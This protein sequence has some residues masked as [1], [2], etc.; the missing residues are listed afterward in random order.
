MAGLGFMNEQQQ[1]IEALPKGPD[2]ID[3]GTCRCSLQA[4]NVQQQDNNNALVSEAWRCTLN[5]TANPYVGASGMWFVPTNTPDSLGLDFAQNE[6]WAGNPPSLQTPYILQGPDNRFNGS[7][8]PYNSESPSGLDSDDQKC[9]G[10]NDTDA[11][12]LYYEGVQKQLQKN[13]LL[14][15]DTCLLKGSVAVPLGNVSYFEKNGCPL[16]F[17]CKSHSLSRIQQI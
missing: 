9:T 2:Y 15:R 13:S 6:S 14:L 1:T 3:S 8:V 5:Q 11:S 4:T 17:L 16:G 7:L 10:Q 12:T